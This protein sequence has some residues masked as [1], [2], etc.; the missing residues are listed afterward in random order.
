MRKTMENILKIPKVIQNPQSWLQKL[1][2]T[3]W[4]LLDMIWYDMI[5]YDMI[6]YDMKGFERVGY[7][8]IIALVD[9][10]AE[11]LAIRSWTVRCCQDWIS[12]SGSSKS[13]SNED[14]IW[15]G[16]SPNICTKIDGDILW[17]PASMANVETSSA[18]FCLR[19]KH[20]ETTFEIGFGSADTLSD[21]GAQPLVPL[22]AGPGTVAATE[23]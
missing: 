8:R 21:P 1:T 13:S 15:Q 22:Q 5:W 20:T 23:G 16:L 3:F 19:L 11:F 12:D 4:N 9:L 14:M 2:I 18:F 10:N 6:W 7:G 17:Y